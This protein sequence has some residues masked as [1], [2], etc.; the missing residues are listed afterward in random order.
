AGNDIIANATKEDL[1]AYQALDKAQQILFSIV[2]DQYQD[3]EHFKDILKKTFDTIQNNYNNKGNAIGLETGFRKLDQLLA[4]LHPGNLFIVGGRPSMGKTAFALS[5]VQNMAIGRKEQ[6]GVG[7]FSLEMSNYELCVR[8]LCAEAKLPMEKLRKNA[9]IESDWPKLIG[10]AERMLQAP[11]Y[12][13]DSPGLTMLELSSKA[14]RMVK[15]GVKFI[16]VDY[17]QLMSG[18]ENGFNASREQFISSV[19]RGLKMLAKELEIPIV[20]LTQLNRS[21]ESRNDKRPLLS[22]IRESGSIEQDADVVCF[23]HRQSF[24]EPEKEDLKN[25]AEVI[26]GKNRHG[27]TGVAT[28]YFHEDYPRFENLLENYE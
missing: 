28:L 13:D 15:L 27:K 1:D 17:L 25:K 16:V 7:I 18:Q 20:A 9:L 14:R 6:M 12:I 5:M 8:L 21:S 23:I 4:G 11:I 10:G 2:K 26:I 19:S 22:D 24:Y 3:F